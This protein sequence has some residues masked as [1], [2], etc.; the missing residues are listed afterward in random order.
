[1]ALPAQNDLCHCGSGRKFKYCCLHY[2]NTSADPDDFEKSDLPEDRYLG[3]SPKEL[4]SIV[5]PFTHHPETICISDSVSSQ[6]TGPLVSLLQTLVERAPI[7][8]D[9]DGYLPDELI[10]ELVAQISALPAYRSFPQENGEREKFAQMVLS[11]CLCTFYGTDLVSFEDNKLHIQLPSEMGEE[12]AGG[13]FR[14]IFPD[15][16]H[17]LIAD[18]GWEVE[19]KDDSLWSLTGFLLFQLARSGTTPTP[20]DSYATE[21]LKAFPELL[22]LMETEGTQQ[23]AISNYVISV[24]FGFWAVMGLVDIEDDDGVPYVTA[25][26]IYHELIQ[27]PEEWLDRLPV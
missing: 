16:F 24:V 21:F 11:T 18:S 22:P 1:M 27:F 8:F 13:D 4:S 15:L 20:A 19:L 5:I 17:S 2:A 6:P 12:L 7:E 14:R 26:P 3:L 9:K 23:D 25:R 10:D